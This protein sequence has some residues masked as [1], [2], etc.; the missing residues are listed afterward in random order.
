M[1]EILQEHGSV[2]VLRF[3]LPYPEAAESLG[4]N[5]FRGYIIRGSTPYAVIER[6]GVRC[7]AVSFEWASF[8][9]LSC[10]LNER[11]P[12]LQEIE[13]T[14][15]QVYGDPLIVDRAD[16]RGYIIGWCYVESNS[17]AELEVWIDGELAGTATANVFRL[18]L[19]KAGIGTGDHGFR[20]RPPNVFLDG[21]EHTIV[22]KKEGMEVTKSL[23]LPFHFDH[24]RPWLNQ[25]PSQPAPVPESEFH[26]AKWRFIEDGDASA[27][28]NLVEL[29]PSLIF[30][31]LGWHERAVHASA[32]PPP[33]FRRMLNRRW[34]RLY[35]PTLCRPDCCKL[36]GA[37]Y[38]SE[39][40]NQ[41][42]DP[43]RHF[44]SKTVMK[45]FARKLGARVPDTLYLFDTPESFYELDLPDA[46]I[47]KPEVDSGIS[48]FLMRG[49]L[50]LFDGF[51]YSK[52]DIVANMRNYL[53]KRGHGR[54]LIES[55]VF[56]EGT[57]SGDEFIPLDYKVHCF[58]GKG[59]IIH[60]DDR[61]CVSRDPLHRSQTWLSRD[62]V[63]A[64]MRM[65]VNEQANRPIKRPNCYDEMLKMADKISTAL[66]DYIRVDFYATDEGPVL[67]EL[68]TYSHSGLGFTDYGQLIMSQ[69][70]AL[71]R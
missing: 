57:N 36:K 45:E 44:A 16:A 3:S 11:L 6:F 70:W 46:Y 54:F 1:N 35:G 37:F 4:K 24:P 48:L 61:N 26:S 68:T 34:M 30:R 31:D 12:E 15:A 25:T 32:L 19:L 49:D 7:D 62:W 42:S 14:P 53:Q 64:P 60:V 2:G 29:H 50:N 13:V 5:G 21:R 59:R 10:S 38:D 55:F 33:N 56:Q 63:E 40:L 58:G 18:D 65:R 28:K 43:L 9:P 20:Y 69:A 8:E 23:K 47:L 27:V 41:C 66:D 71:F 67:G 39:L 17:H 22:V 51:R 52:E